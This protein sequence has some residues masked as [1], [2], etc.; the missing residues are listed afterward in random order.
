VS[1]AQTRNSR[2]DPRRRAIYA[3]QRVSTRTNPAG[4]RGR[5]SSGWSGTRPR[6]RWQDRALGQAAEDRRR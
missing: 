1:A 4:S 5:G 6:A 2:P 3:G